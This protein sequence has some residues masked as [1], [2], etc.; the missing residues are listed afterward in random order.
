[1]LTILGHMSRKMLERYS[2]IRL[3]AKREAVEL[4]LVFL[5][6]P[7]IR[8]VARIEFPRQAADHLSAAG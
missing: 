3:Q 1:M 4:S 2:H 8:T 5:A 6:T 7:V